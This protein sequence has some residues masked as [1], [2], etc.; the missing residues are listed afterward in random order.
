MPRNA[1]ASPL[2]RL[3]FGL[4][5]PGNWKPALLRLGGFWLLLAVVFFQD[6][7]NIADQAWNVSTYSHILLIPAIL[8]WL[9]W[10]RAG[11]I[12]KLEPKGWWPGLVFC[13]GAAFLWLLGAFSGLDFAKQVGAVSL[14]VLSVP[15]LLGI[16]VG[17]ALLFPL[18]YA[19]MLVPFGDEM[20][21]ALQMTTAEITIFLVEVS[22]IPAVIDGVFI[23]TPAGLFEVAE[24]CSG[25]KFLIAMIALGFL[26]GNV[27][28]VS[29][30]RRIAFFAACVIV[31]ILANGVR[32]WATVYA[33]QIFGIEA[34]AG[35]DHIVYG[36]FFFAIVVVIVLAAGWRYF[37]RP[38]DEV[39]ID[40]KRIAAM[41]LLGRLEAFAIKPVAA[42]I[43]LVAML[44]AIFAWAQAANALSA[45]L[46][47][48]VALPVVEGWEAVEYA[49]QVWWKPRAAGA[50]RTLIATYR[51]AQ[52]QQVD[53]F[54]AAYASQG[55][56]REAG[57][58]GEGALV[59]D[60]EWSWQSSAP[61]LDGA[62]T[63]RLLARGSVER[64][65][66]TW[67]R[68]GSLT[69]GSNARLKLANMADRLLFRARPT[70]TLMLSA[71]DRPGM[72]ATD[73][74]RAF[75][76]DIE[77]VGAWMDRAAGVR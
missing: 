12:V 37:D 58:Q 43:G 72:P 16:R 19:F 20:V 36:W 48:Q 40:A 64:V 39:P 49:P 33:A 77:P 22:R 76:S 53:V 30:K 46:S 3:R 45:N 23:D 68:T 25:V 35:F 8:G 26:I 32:A 31:P 70:T 73:A 75:H 61:A 66:Y 29:W 5:L 62:R 44:A 9:V 1:I 71:E 14:L 74:I 41:P 17:A 6:W 67:Y 51:N 34:A 13:A 24:A 28:F 56:G 57:G 38:V 50:D 69:T 11:E 15:T 55:E 47:G 65:A 60:S 18:A 59:P 42:L 63:D 27:C 2:E 4:E 21:P 7:S 10:Q 54:I 52:G